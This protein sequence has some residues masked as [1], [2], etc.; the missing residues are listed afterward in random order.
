MN[1]CES[2]WDN[3]DLGLMVLYHYTAPNM[4]LLHLEGNTD[5]EYFLS[6]FQQ[7]SY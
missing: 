3:V 6:N 2:L 4:A 5:N 7:Q 1:E